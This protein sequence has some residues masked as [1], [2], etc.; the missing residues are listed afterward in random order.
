MRLVVF[1]SGHPFRGGVA[2]TTTELVRALEAHG[3]E[4]RFLTP[5]RQYPRWLFP[6]T[7]DRDPEAC[8]RLACAEAVLEPLNPL[9]WP[10]ARLRALAIAADAWLVPYWTWAW[11]GWWRYLL[12]GRHPPAVAVVHNPA[13]HDSGLRHRLAARS[14]LRRCEGLFTHARVLEEAL[15]A[16]HP[17]RPTASCPLPATE[18]GPLP[19]RAAARRELGLA[20][21]PR[22]ALFMGLIRPYKGVVLLLEA[23]ARLPAASDW[24]LVVAGEPWGEQGAL[25]ERKVRELGIGRRVHL[26]LGWVPEPEVPRLLVA[27]DLVVLPYRSGS[28][29]AVAPLALAA[30]VPVLSTAVGG[31]AEIVRHGVDGWIVEPGSAEALTAALEALERPL[32]EQL[33]GGARAGAGRPSWDAYAAALEGLIER[34][35]ERSNVQRSKV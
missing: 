27:A 21:A 15:A 7:D 20:A 16:A 23:L 22:L 33:A 13:D 19:E 29:S 12:R 1:G 4:V 25:V 34:V 9:A 14:V 11:A 6:G 35:I 30:G 26:R 32:L 10:A 18:V 3:H 24:E 8:P 2:R 17:G 28:Q 31:L 5:R